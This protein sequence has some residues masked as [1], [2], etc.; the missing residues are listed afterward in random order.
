[1]SNLIRI[2]K[3]ESMS[4]WIIIFTSCFYNK[5]L[6]CDINHSSQFFD[7]REECEQ[8]SNMYLV[9]GLCVKTRFEL[10]P[11]HQ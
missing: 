4:F 7:S 8:V 1:L 5:Y 6:S 10:K 3:G 11:F 9:P 2:N